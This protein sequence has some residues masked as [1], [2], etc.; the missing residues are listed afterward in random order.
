MANRKW[1]DALIGFLVQLEE[2]QD[3]R[4]LAILRRGASGEPATRIA[5]MPLVL[6]R[7]PQTEGHWA[8]DAAL[9]VASLF[10][11]HPLPGGAAATFGGSMGQ[12]ARGQPSRDSADARFTTLLMSHSDDVDGHLRHAVRLLA[13]KAIPVRWDQL[14]TDVQFWGHEDLFVQ[15]RWAQ[16]Y[17]PYENSEASTIETS[18]THPATPSGT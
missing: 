9:L 18:R 1:I 11:L 6:P 5:M 2:Q 10:G 13:A 12:Y 4:A 3:R 15:R 14:L 8:E 16:D 7:V 17:W